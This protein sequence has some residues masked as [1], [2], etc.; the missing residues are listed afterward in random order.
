MLPGLYSVHTNE[1]LDGENRHFTMAETLIAA[2]Q[3]A[4]QLTFMPDSSLDEPPTN[5]TGSNAYLTHLIDV[6]DPRSPAIESG[7]ELEIPTHPPPRH[8]ISPGVQGPTA[9]SSP[10]RAASLD[11]GGTL[12]S[13]DGSTT[14][15][16]LDLDASTQRTLS[17][18]TASHQGHQRSISDVSRITIESEPGVGDTSSCNT[19]V[20]SP[21]SHSP[22]SSLAPTEFGDETYATGSPASVAFGWLRSFNDETADDSPT[23]QLMAAMQLL[24]QPGQVPQDLL[25]SPVVTPGDIAA[26]RILKHQ[27]SLRG[28][29]DWAPPRNQIMFDVK[30]RVDAKSL[31]IKK[32]GYRCAGCGLRVEINYIKVGKVFP[33]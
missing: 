8:T 9:T 10:R 26:G 32:Q 19:S 31:A 14:Q 18:L 28:N 1:R 4:T 7:N 22:V 2:L 3:E 13:M 24:V 6:L 12:R 11:H 33:R 16:S 23:S 30:L 5:I 29:Q 17:P 27:Q 15:R 20:L 25:P 21:P